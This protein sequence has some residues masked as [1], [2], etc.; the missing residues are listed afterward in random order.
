MKPNDLAS[1]ETPNFM[2]IDDLEDDSTNE[3]VDISQPLNLQKNE[4]I[5]LNIQIIHLPTTNKQI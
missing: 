4:W 3:W 2:F 1:K 5:L